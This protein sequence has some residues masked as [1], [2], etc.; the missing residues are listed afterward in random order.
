SEQRLAGIWDD[1]R[2]AQVRQTFLKAA[3]AEL[4]V[5]G[6]AAQLERTTSALDAYARDW[7]AMHREA[8]AAA[9]ISGE[10][11]EAVLSLRMACLER[12]GRREDAERS[13]E[14]ATY[15]A[16]AGR[17]DVMKARAASRLVFLCGQ[18]YAVDRG[19]HWKEV[20]SAALERAGPNPELEGELL[21]NAGTLAL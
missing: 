5:S 3:P 13:L 2:R 8:C 19:R 18:G 1:A 15:A 12:L 7:A 20:A 14:A 16:D 9:R 21:N 4:G 10:Q 6:A 11:T 17:D